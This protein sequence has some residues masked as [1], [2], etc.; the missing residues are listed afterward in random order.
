MKCGA[1]CRVVRQTAAQG[2]ENPRKFGFSEQ[3]WWLLQQRYPRNQLV[4]RAIHGQVVALNLGCD[5]LQLAQRLKVERNAPHLYQLDQES[6]KILPEL[7]M[8]GLK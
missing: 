3:L 6:R 5:F 8:D 7:P 1:Q 4:D 2:I